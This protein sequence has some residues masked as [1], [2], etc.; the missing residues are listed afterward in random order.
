MT[1]TAKDTLGEHQAQP[2]VIKGIPDASAPIVRILRSNRKTMVGRVLADGSIE[3]RAPRT[4]TNERI[5]AWLD[6]LAPRFRPLIE[7][8][9]RTNALVA[10]HPFG[11]GGEVLYRG[12]WLP[13]K[14]TSDD[15][16]GYAVQLKANAIIAAPGLS[17]AAMRQQVES[18]LASLA[19]PI[20]EEKLRRY[21][22]LM[23]LRYKTWR[24]GSARK[25]HGSCDS[26]GKIILSWRIIMMSEDVV[27]YIVVHELAHL[28]H[29]NHSKD[30]Y[31]VV[32][33]VLPDWKARRAAHGEF[34][35]LLRSGGWL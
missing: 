27:D 33:S 7:E 5:Y 3:V 15:N 12:E 2:T 34:C 17:E 22:E 31:N 4:V 1:N 6:E 30:F 16:D 18:L 13:I 28:K 24:I 29:L 21:S 10:Q 35:K 19:K 20:F 23:N 11:Y 25:R 26:N 9:R 32:A 14:E 8:C